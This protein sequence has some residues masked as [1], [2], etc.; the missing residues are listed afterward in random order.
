MH[1]PAT[2]SIAR[3][4]TIHR[5]VET[6]T[7]PSSQCGKECATRGIPFHSLRTSLDSAPDHSLHV[8]SQPCS[9][10]TLRCRFHLPKGPERA[11]R[12]YGS[13]YI[14]DAC[15][16]NAG[17]WDQTASDGQPEKETG[18]ILNLGDQS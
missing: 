8:D 13:K 2:E 7:D 14:R 4:R 17:Q 1:I 18:R 9:L 12:C 5:Y 11:M 16:A 6:V 3:Q 15:T 10:S